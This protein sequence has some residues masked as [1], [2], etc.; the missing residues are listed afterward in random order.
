MRSELI[1]G[2]IVSCGYVLRLFAEHVLFG[3]NTVIVFSAY[4]HIYDM[5]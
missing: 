3:V 5:A 2:Q 1:L 4:P